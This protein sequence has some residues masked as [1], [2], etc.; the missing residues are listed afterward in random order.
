M[1]FLIEDDFT[2]YTDN[3]TVNQIL[4]LEG[5]KELIRNRSEKAAIEEVNSFLHKKFET[6]KI[7]EKTGDE[8]NETIVKLLVNITAWYFYSKLDS[9]QVPEVRQLRYAESIKELEQIANGIKYLDCEKKQTNRIVDIISDPK[10]DN[11][12]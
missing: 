12:Y 9:D 11:Q 2:V 7:Y 6:E 8:R 1:K 10:Q 5:K 3:D 4:N